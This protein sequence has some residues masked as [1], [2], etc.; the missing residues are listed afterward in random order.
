MLKA[1]AHSKVKCEKLAQKVYLHRDRNIIPYHF[2]YYFNIIFLI[3]FSFSMWRI[4][5]YLSQVVFLQPKLRKKEKNL[6][7]SACFPSLPLLIEFSFFKSPCL[8]SR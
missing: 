3:N 5:R 1:E 4:Y 7:W 8:F 6:Q 2:C